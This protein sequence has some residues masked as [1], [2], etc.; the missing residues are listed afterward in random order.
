VSVEITDGSGGTLTI[1]V[2]GKLRH[3]ELARAQASAVHAIGKHGKVRLLVVATG[4][5]GWERA[6]DW[7]DTSFS[8]QHDKDIEKLAIV[9]DRRWEDLIVA[10][11][12]KGVRR[13]AIEYFP[14]A[15]LA[16]ARAWI[17]A[18]P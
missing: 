16:R 10:F 8:A 5:D 11:T 2:T 17:D 18:R 3:G 15:D 14:T 4:F 1:T 7:S 13:T 9:A 12:G 6:D